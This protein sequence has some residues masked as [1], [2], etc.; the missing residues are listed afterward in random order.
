MVFWA[1]KNSVLRIR[2]KDDKFTAEYDGRR[3]SFCGDECCHE[4]M[5]DPKKYIATAE[6]Q[7]IE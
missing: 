7:R 6:V 5:H 2:L 4:F 3:Y 1:Q